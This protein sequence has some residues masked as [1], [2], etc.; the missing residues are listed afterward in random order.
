MSV[1]P[2]SSEPRLVPLRVETL[3][4]GKRAATGLV[5]DRFGRIW[6][7]FTVVMEGHSEGDAFV[8][9]EWFDFDDGE[10]SHRIW[11]I[12][13]LEDGTYEGEAADVEGL[14]RGRVENGVLRWAY[15]MVLKIG[16]REWKIAFD[17]RM[18]PASDGTLLNIARMHKG[19]ITLGRITIAFRP[20]A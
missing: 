19:G 18:Y 7:R 20:L 11:R 2:V 4:E 3:F 8:L 1:D 10:K 5:E 12:R 17:D 6:R 15:R 16:G 13:S 14:A 9:D